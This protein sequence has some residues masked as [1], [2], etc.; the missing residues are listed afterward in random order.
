MPISNENEH[1]ES[2][3]QKVNLLFLMTLMNVM[4]KLRKC[5]G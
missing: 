3:L 5:L 4:M 2:G 1:K